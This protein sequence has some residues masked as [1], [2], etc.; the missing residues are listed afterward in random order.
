MRTNQRNRVARCRYRQPSSDL[1]QPGSECLSARFPAA[2]ET[3]EE[4]VFP[5]V[6][7]SMGAAM[8]SQGY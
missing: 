4:R 2:A 8:A 1:R 3:F 6:H 7:A 5:I